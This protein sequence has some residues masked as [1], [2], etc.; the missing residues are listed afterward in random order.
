MLFQ[1]DV[2][3]FSKAKQQNE[4]NKK[5]LHS[6]GAR[7]FLVSGLGAYGCAPVVV[8]LTNVTGK[9][10]CVDLVNDA[11]QM[12]NT[13]LMSLVDELN[14]EFTDSKFVMLNSYDLLLG[15]S[16]AEGFKHFYNSSCCV[17]PRAGLCQP[18]KAPC[19]NRSEY[20]FWDVF[21]PSDKANAV[22]VGQAYSTDNRTITYP[23]NIRS[24]AKL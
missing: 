10:G 15:L 13:K 3:F 8:L 16:S 11:V 6:Y 20:I 21:H 14:Q 4:R 22:M 7:K 12:F 18:E 17:V 19:P 24:L 23:L 1:F 5:A 2:P 9:S